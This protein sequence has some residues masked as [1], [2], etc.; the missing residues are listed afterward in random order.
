MKINN[1]EGRPVPGLGRSNAAAPARESEG[2]AITG[3]GKSSLEGDRVQLSNLSANLTATL[4]DSA[5]HSTKLS[6]L[7][8]AVSIGGYHVDA[9]IVGDGLIRHSLQFGGSNYI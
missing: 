8:S 2:G 1:S 7:S 3:P 4:S 5:A 6:A 9:G